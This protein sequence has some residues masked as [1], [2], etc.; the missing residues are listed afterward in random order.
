[1]TAGMTGGTL[2]G[3]RGDGGPSSRRAR[4]DGADAAPLRRDRHALSWAWPCDLP[5]EPL[6]AV[7]GRSYAP[8]GEAGGRTPGASRTGARR[9]SSFLAVSSM[10]VTIRF[11]PRPNR[12][13]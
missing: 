2:V 13:L 3:R 1:M 12:W 4:C 7:P 5:P 6:L 8:V 9:W 10:T 11:G